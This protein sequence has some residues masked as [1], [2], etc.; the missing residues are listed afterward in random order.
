MGEGLG[1][2]VAGDGLVEG[3]G[4]VGLLGTVTSV[5]GMVTSSVGVVTSSVGVVASSVGVV[6]SSVGVLASSVGVVAS[7]VGVVAGVVA[8]IVGVVSSVVVVVVTGEVIGSGTAARHNNMLT[9]QEKETVRE[10]KQS[11]ADTIFHCIPK[12]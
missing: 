11:L 3:V 4:S 8:S 5:V 7:V 2:S 6:A 9:F 12:L 1:G 10:S